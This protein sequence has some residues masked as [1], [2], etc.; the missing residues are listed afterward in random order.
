MCMSLQTWSFV[1]LICPKVHRS[2]VIIRTTQVT[3]LIST[4]CKAIGNEASNP[5]RPLSW[6]IACH[7]SQWQ[8]SQ[9]VGDHKLQDRTNVHIQP[10]HRHEPLFR[11]SRHVLTS[12]RTAATRR[13]LAWNAQSPWSLSL[14]HWFCRRVEDRDGWLPGRRPGCYLLLN[15]PRQQPPP[16]TLTA[17]SELG[18]HCIDSKDYSR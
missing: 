6:S 8:E 16:Y 5:M 10:A 11:E 17:W 1:L 7:S 3:T 15:L 13:T 18:M 4:D 12:T 14:P 2:L 9:T